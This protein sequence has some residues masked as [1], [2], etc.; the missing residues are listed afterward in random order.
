MYSSV[1]Q[2][3]PELAAQW[4]EKNHP[5]NRALREKT[6]KQYA[7]MMRRG[8]WQLSP[9]GVSFTQSGY[10]IDGQHRLAAV[11]KSGCTVPMYVTFDA[12]DNIYILDAGTVR[13]P[14]AHMHMRGLDITKNEIAMIRFLLNWVGEGTDKNTPMI[15]RI[16][17][18]YADSLH[19]AYRFCTHGNV[20][21]SATRK[22][23]PLMLGACTA[24]V[25]AALTCGC[26][27]DKL[28]RFCTVTNSGFSVSSGETSAIVLRNVLDGMGT[29]LADNILK[30]QMTQMAI[31]DFMAGRSRRNIW[32]D[33][34]A[35]YFDGKIPE[36]LIRTAIAATPNK[37]VVNA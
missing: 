31:Q 30:F 22:S 13:G 37:E 7:D 24:G 3:T 12:P 27:R 26:D 18:R 17:S 20:S 1:I 16:A 11:V 34:K 25:W 2:V 15:E 36:N 5:N 21:S 9:Q 23:P 35:V 29:H 33:P 28:D 10:L 32:K 19:D 4:L 8:E 14:Q 6:V